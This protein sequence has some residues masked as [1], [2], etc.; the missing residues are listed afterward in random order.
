MAPGDVEVVLVDKPRTFAQSQRRQRDVRRR[1]RQFPRAITLGT[2]VELVEVDPLPAHGNLD[3]AVKFAKRECRRHQNAPPYHGAD[4]AQPDFDLQDCV[5]VRRGYRGL[6]FQ[7]GRL[8][9]SFHPVRLAPMW[10]AGARHPRHPYA[11][12]FRAAAGGSPLRLLPFVFQC[13]RED[14]SH[15][16]GN[17]LT[18]EGRWTSHPAFATG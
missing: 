12:Q 5:G 8:R 11:L 9:P 6:L 4:P 2:E 17:G 14:G 10:P 18:Q 3:H 1:C 16:S 15:P 13:P 7:T